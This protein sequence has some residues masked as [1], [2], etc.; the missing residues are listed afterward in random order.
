MT[1]SGPEHSP[2]ETP[3]RPGWKLFLLGFL[4][5]YLELALIRY[6]AGSIWNLGYFPNLVLL[7]TFVGMGTGFLLHRYITPRWSPFVFAGAPVA[8]LLLVCLAKFAAPALPG[9]GQHGTEIAG[10]I[11]F[12]AT[13]SGE[14]GGSYLIFGLWFLS[15]AL[16]FFCVSQRT[17]KLFRL[18]SP[19][20]SY[21]LDISGSIGGI[22]SFMLLSWLEMPAYSWFLV[23]LPLYLLAMDRTP[24]IPVL[25]PVLVFLCVAG[26]VWD[27]DLLLMSN[28][29]AE[30]KLEVSWSPYQKMEYF[31]APDDPAQY[32]YANGIAHQN[33]QPAEDFGTSWYSAAYRRRKTLGLPDYKTVLVI[34]AGSGNDVA[35]ALLNGAEHVDA[36][37]IDPAIAE[38]GR[39]YHP[40]RPYDDPRVTLEIDDGRAFLRRTRR[41]YDLIVFALTDSLVKVSA[42]AQLRL[43]NYLFTENSMRRAASRLTDSGDIVFYNFYRQPW[44]IDKYQHMCLAATGK[45][46]RTIYKVADFEGLIVSPHA[47]QPPPATAG[48]SDVDIPTDDWPFPYLRK[49]GMPTLYLKALLAVAA[50]IVLLGFALRRLERRRGEGATEAGDLL[51]KIAFVLMGLA[52]LLLETKSI[53]QFSLLFGTTWINTSMVFL[54]V[55]TLVLAANWVGK[56]PKAPPLVVIYALLLASCLFSLFYPLSNLLSLDS[57]PLR[58]ALASLIT[59]TPIFFANLLF[60]VTFRH[61]QV[62]EQ[63]FGWN[64]LGATLGGLLE[65]SSMALGYNAL[66]VI[67]ALC[68]TATFALLLLARR[69]KARRAL[70][71]PGPER[72][73]EPEPTPTPTPS[74]SP[75]SPVPQGPRPSPRA[76]GPRRPRPGRA[77]AGRPRSCC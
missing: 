56:L 72:A 27:Q 77:A 38:L 49:R 48:R 59:F 34:G 24:S 64:L 31:K 53:V 45:W 16:V 69:R 3:A 20:K 73:P 40:L 28:P 74:P 32:L 54:A 55:L 60:S 4:T 11:Y 36:V 10:E 65:Y 30:G 9:F 75:R 2:S 22:L 29:R 68:Y 76:A 46:P 42:M 47:H 23:A 19:L 18:F 14:A 52:F 66:A 44:L 13:P 1:M 50:M 17:A 8:L 39:R 63:M 71:S 61:Q 5:L 25:A 51:T 43:E 41:R 12:T 35:A 67:V 58:F 33:M 15:V 7:A 6:L 70:D 37:E 21:T 26:L 57:A 62:A